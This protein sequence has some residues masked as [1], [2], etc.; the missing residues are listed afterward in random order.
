MPATYL[1]SGGG[2]S[3]VR[4]NPSE[5]ALPNRFDGWYRADGGN[6]RA[7]RPIPAHALCRRIWIPSYEAGVGHPEAGGVDARAMSKGN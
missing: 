6:K 5:A 7:V 2:R 1:I 3:L 4:Y